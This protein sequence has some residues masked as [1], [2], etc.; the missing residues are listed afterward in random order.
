MQQTDGPEASGI[1]VKL[2]SSIQTVLSVPE[3]HRFSLRSRTLPPVGN[4]TLP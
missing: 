3:S 4:C 1:R 2:S